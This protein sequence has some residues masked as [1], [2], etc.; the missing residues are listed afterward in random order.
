MKTKTNTKMSTNRT[1]EKGTLL[2]DVLDGAYVLAAGKGTRMGVVGKRLPKPL[3]PVF[4]KSLLSLQLS[5]CEEQN[6]KIVYINVH[7]LKEFVI[8]HIEKIKNNFTFKVVILEEEPLL[9]SGGNVHNL[10]RHTLPP[11]SGTYMVLNSDLFYF[12]DDIDYQ[13]LMREIHVLKNNEIQNFH[14]I[15]LGVWV[16]GRDGYNETII[17]NENW[18]TDIQ[19]VKQVDPDKVHVTYSG[20]GIIRLNQLE[21]VEGVSKFFESVCNFRKQKVKMLIP[22]RESCYIDFGTKESYLASLENLISWIDTYLNQGEGAISEVRLSFLSFLERSEGVHFP[23]FIGDQY[24]G[25]CIFQKDVSQLIFKIKTL[26]I[27]FERFNIGHSS[28]LLSDDYKNRLA[29]FQ[30]SI[31]QAEDSI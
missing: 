14:S 19:T 28:L 31:F 21:R 2:G 11:Y 25:F 9:D 6:F 5:W 27:C 3:W 10:G 13:N 22:Q 15:L 30:D 12:L 18:L 16:K 26:H 17:D 23:K 29:F 4:E 24:E 8:S 20:V 7:Y 1:V